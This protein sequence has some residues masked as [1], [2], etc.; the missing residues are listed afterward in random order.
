MIITRQSPFTG[1][2]NTMD[3]DVTQ[4]QI[5]KWKAGTL[6]QF[7]MPNLTPDEREFIMTGIT[8]S[9]WGA[10]FGEDVEEDNTQEVD[11]TL[12]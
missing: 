10:T 4:A 11:V 8:P 7:A 3:I 12:N 2:L 6:I 5:D 9:E 1:R